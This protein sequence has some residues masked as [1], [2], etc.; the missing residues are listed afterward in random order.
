L[1]RWGVSHELLVDTVAGIIRR[2]IVGLA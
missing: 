1:E 2:T